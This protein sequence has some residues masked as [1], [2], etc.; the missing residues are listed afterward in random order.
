MLVVL[1]LKKFLKVS[2]FIAH[3]FKFIDYDN[4]ITMHVY[5][6]TFVFITLSRVY[7]IDLSSTFESDRSSLKR[8]T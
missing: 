7:R 1:Y 3:K 4:R 2:D 6:K 8:V 5:M